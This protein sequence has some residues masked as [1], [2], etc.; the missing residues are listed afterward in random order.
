MKRYL[1]QEQLNSLDQ[2]QKETLLK[3][4]TFEP[5]DFFLHP[6]HLGVQVVPE[7]DSMTNPEYLQ[8]GQLLPSLAQVLDFINLNYPGHWK[9]VRTVNRL[10]YMRIGDFH[11][12]LHEELIDTAFDAVVY[13]LKLEN[14][15]K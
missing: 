2:L 6:D 10:W 14:E 1:S 3:T 9:A 15:D 7:E 8:E 11:T 12:R 4:F 13:L 5:G